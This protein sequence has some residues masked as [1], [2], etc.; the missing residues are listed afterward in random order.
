LRYY[1]DRFEL[2]HMSLTRSCLA[3]TYGSGNYFSGLSPLATRAREEVDLMEIAAGLF[4][5]TLQLV[6][7]EDMSY[8]R[9]A[10]ERYGSRQMTIGGRER[11]VPRSK[12]H[13]RRI[14]AEFFTALKCFMP[15]AQ[16]FFVSNFYV[17]LPAR[18]K[19][20]SIICGNASR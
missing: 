12:Q 15:A 7:I 20:K 6:A 13:S 17:D 5:R 3:E 11:I 4:S 9:I 18:A 16:S 14:K 1:R 8:N 10:I 19:H 2:S